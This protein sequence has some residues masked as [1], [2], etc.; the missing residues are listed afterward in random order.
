[1][2]AVLDDYDSQR[3]RPLKEIIVMKAAAGAAFLAVMFVVGS[4]SMRA[5]TPQTTAAKPS[6]STLDQQIEARIHKDPSL[7][8]RDVDVS[9]ADGVVTLKGKVASEAQ[10]RKAA[11]LSML[12]GVARVNNQ[13]V[14]DLEKSTTKTIENKTKAGAEKAADKTKEAVSTGGEVI[15]DAWITTRVRG[16]FVGE[17]LLKDS[18]IDVD[19]KDH[20]VTLTG[21]VR[22]T[23]G[24][25][26]AVAQA[27]EVEGVHRV[28]DRLTI[29]Q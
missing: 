1:M 20:V 25:S 23:A 18:K 3:A 15:T 28:V 11:Q 4:A 27:K 7:K 8:S 22:T 10:R 26:R 14:V 5:A 9:V 13:L 19:T 29:G 6:D 17:D 21:T 12:P 2:K 16:K 24:R